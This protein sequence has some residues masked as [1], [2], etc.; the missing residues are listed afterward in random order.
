MAPKLT[1]FAAPSA[2]QG[3]RRAPWG[4]QGPSGGRAGL[5]MGSHSTARVLR[6]DDGRFDERANALRALAI[7]VVQ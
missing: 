5:V 4:A 1:S 2:P 3:H 7:D 6:P